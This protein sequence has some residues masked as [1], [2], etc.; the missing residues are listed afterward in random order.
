MVRNAKLPGDS[1]T[2]QRSIP[3]S[4]PPNSPEP[5]ASNNPNKKKK[6][7]KK[8]GREEKDPGKK[9]E[10]KDWSTKRHQLEKFVDA[11]TGEEQITK[12][13]K[14][15]EK[16]VLL[17]LK[18]CEVV[19]V[20][21]VEELENKM[22]AVTM[23]FLQDV[24]PQ[25]MIELKSFARSLLKAV[26]KLEKKGWCHGDIKRSNIR[27]NGERVTLIDMEMSQR[28]G[29][30]VVGHTKGYLA[31]EAEESKVVSNKT[32]VYAIGILLGEELL[33][34]KFAKIP[35][36]AKE[37][38]EEVQN[39]ANQLPKEM[40]DLIFKLTAKHHAKRITIKQALEHC[41][42]QHPQPLSLLHHPKPKNNNNNN[43]N[44]L[45]KTNYVDQHQEAFKE[46]IIPKSSNIVKKP[47][48]NILLRENRRPLQEI[49]K[50][51][52]RKETGKKKVKNA[53]KNI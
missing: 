23:P 50:Q 44:T 41:W 51:C 15:R 30:R 16:E 48:D 52:V 43:N 9:T 34:V 10:K 28:F 45:L 49:H 20:R 40:S 33:R 26:E 37:V 47:N 12:V 42:F 5:D 53:G 35:C 24:D 6:D 29:D 36:E 25:N 39:R 32:D 38:I 11:E 8:N 2:S 7:S 4:E 13:M 31:P 17:M 21:D 27:W 14:E 19:Q 1:S 22:Y 46:N 18:D 3:T